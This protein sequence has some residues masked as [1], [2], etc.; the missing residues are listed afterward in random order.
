MQRDDRRGRGQW[1]GCHS[2]RDIFCDDVAGPGT[3]YKRHGGLKMGHTYYYYYEVD[4]AVETHNP[5]LPSTTS[6]PYMPGQTVNTMIVP[7]E[8]A[9]RKRSASLSSMRPTDF[10]TMNPE[11]KF[12]TPRPARSALADNTTFRLGSSPHLHHKSSTRSLSPAPAWKRFF[13]RKLTSHDGER[14]R[15][16]V[17]ETQPRS[18]PDDS[19]VRC[20]T[21]SEGTRTR[22][23]SPESLRRFL[24]DDVPSRPGSNLSVRPTLVIPD[25]TPVENDNE[26]D[27]DDDDNFA[28]SAISE[29][30]TYTTGL[31]PP[32]FRRTA[33]SE[34]IGRTANNPTSLTLMPTRPSN[35]TVY[36]TQEVPASAVIP[37]RPKLETFSSGMTLSTSSSYFASP[38]SPQY[39]D[40]DAQAFYYDWTDDEDDML[41]SNNSDITSF[42][43]TANTS[44]KTESYECYSLPEPEEERSK[45]VEPQPAYAKIN[46]PAL[47]SQGHSDLTVSGSNLLGSPIDTGLDDFVSE[48]GWMVGI[49]GKRD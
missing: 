13:S 39:P 12:A 37:S 18:V 32:P 7:V 27:N 46:S 24:S 1:R 19:D 30:Q 49:I 48:L 31:T 45:I 38:V 34:S 20:T 43:P 47:L 3:P 10:M 4:G 17:R 28:T 35:L 6:C 11:S 16:P 40:D 21:P 41:S 29:N 8:Q 23:I 36:E 26:E 2:F 42:Q 5:T 33:S 14:G 15:S 22:D 44:N 25:E 9:L